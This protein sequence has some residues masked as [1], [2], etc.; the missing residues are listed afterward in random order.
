MER[1][2]NWDVYAQPLSFVYNMQM[3]CEI[4][5]SIFAV[6]LPQEPQCAETFDEVTEIRTDVPAKTPPH[7]LK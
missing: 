3:H 5:M 6:I 1:H 4:G 7:D 2:G